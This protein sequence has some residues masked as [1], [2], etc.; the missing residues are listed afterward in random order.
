[1][2]IL[3]KQAALKSTLIYLAI[4]VFITMSF[5]GYAQ[6]T[7]G[8]L[9]AWLVSVNILLFLIM[10]KDKLSSILGMSRTPEGT[11]LWLAAV[12][13]FPSLF[14]SR[15]VFNHKTSKEEFIKPMWLLLILQIGA[16]IYY[17]AVLDPSF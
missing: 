6:G 16:F 5:Q 8:T 15:L 12:G 3:F 1:M 4:C 2:S 7:L 17:F 9:G 11:L 14:I 10:G 13:A